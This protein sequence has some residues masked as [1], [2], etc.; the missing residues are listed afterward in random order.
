MDQ[1]DAKRFAEACSCVPLLVTL[2]ADAVSGGRIVVQVGLGDEVTRMH[3]THKKLI[4]S[5]SLPG[6]FII[7]YFR[8]RSNNLPVH[9]STH[10]EIYLYIYLWIYLPV[11][12]LILKF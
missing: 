7:I 8:T 5:G 6:R 11:Y 10:G 1:G 4:R 2:A 9:R 12:V 3:R